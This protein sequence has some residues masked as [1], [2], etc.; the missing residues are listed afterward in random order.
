MSLVID[1]DECSTA[2]IAINSNGDTINNSNGD[3]INDSNRDTSTP[4]P[5]DWTSPAPQGCYFSAVGV[6][7]LNIKKHQK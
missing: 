3:T 2:A 7:R 6:L 1:P 4:K 5:D